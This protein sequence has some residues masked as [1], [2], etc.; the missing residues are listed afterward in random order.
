[1]QNSTSVNIYDIN[2]T[3]NEYVTGRITLRNFIYKW[4][5]LTEICS[6][7]ILFWSS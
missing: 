2:D 4:E 1:M 6:F 7:R 5:I 3:H